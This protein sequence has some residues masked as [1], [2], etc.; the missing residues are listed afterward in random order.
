MAPRM[1]GCASP[2]GAASSGSAASRSAA[3]SC[4]SS[5]RA[6]WAWR[7]QKIT[8]CPASTADDRATPWRSGSRPTR[9]STWAS[10]VST[11]WAMP[12]PGGAM[13]A[14]VLRT[15]VSA[16]CQSLPSSSTP[17]S[18]SRRCKAGSPLSPVTRAPR[19]SVI[20]RPSPS[21]TQPWAMPVMQGTPAPKATPEKPPLKMPRASACCACRSSVR[22]A[23]C[24]PSTP[25]SP[26][27]PTPPNSR[28]DSVRSDSSYSNSASSGWPPPAWTRAEWAVN[29]ASPPGACKGARPEYRR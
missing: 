6:T 11:P 1:R 21:G 26:S 2:S 23:I 8:E 27:S 22:Q 28:P 18:C 16:G 14:S 24:T 9:V 19:A 15:V 20:S 10:S 7:R 12:R 25:S 3:P 4:S 29:P 17:S 5:W 13:A